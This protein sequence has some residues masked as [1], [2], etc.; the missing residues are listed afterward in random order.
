MSINDGL[1]KKRGYFCSLFTTGI[2]IIALLICSVAITAIIANY[3]YGIMHSLF[4][5]K[6]ELNDGV[7]DLFTV[8]G[9]V[10]G[11][12]LIIFLVIEIFNR[13]VGLGDALSI[14]LVLAG[15]FYI[16][17]VITVLKEVTLFRVLGGSLAIVFGVVFITLR[18]IFFK[19]FQAKAPREYTSNTIVDIFASVNA[20][21][22]FLSILLTACV[23]VI[24][25]FLA[26]NPNFS[27]IV[28]DTLKY[29]PVLKYFGIAV[30]AVGVIFAFT[31]AFSKKTNFL[32]VI[33][34]SGI[35]VAP[36]SLIILLGY[37]GKNPT[38][39][40]TYLII[41]ATYLLL[42]IIRNVAI[43]LK[44]KKEEKSNGG[45]FKQLIKK[46][47]PILALLTAFILVSFV[48]LVL[49]TNAINE[50]FFAQNGQVA[51]FSYKFALLIVLALVGAGVLLGSLVGALLNL[52]SKRVTLG[53]FGLLTLL[54][55]SL[56]TFAILLV[57]SSLIFIIVT[58]CVSAI[59]LA[60]FITRIIIVEKN[61]IK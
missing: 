43:N 49:R 61:K 30:G 35:I 11:A 52:T 57:Y 7:Y 50:Y 8:L 23:F 32:D 58:A 26:F 59:L 21:F 25:T 45:Y 2:F 9:I 46:C 55:T 14:A 60:L 1:T 4:I 54:L 24:A 41:L 19:K 16:V 38:L 37:R 13:K 42:V 18:A 36:L 34:W 12:L 3:D 33:L 27:G 39:L 51:L 29:Y 17:Y 22:S 44:N 53:D 31:S 10:A 47:N 40:T 56:S 5:R 20:K 6:Q 28:R 48:A 15:G